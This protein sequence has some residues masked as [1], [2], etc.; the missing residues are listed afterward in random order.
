MYSKDPIDV[1]SKHLGTHKYIHQ[2]YL[3]WR[4]AI[5][6]DPKTHENPDQI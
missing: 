3:S 6:I 5:Q 4:E 2:M 1:L